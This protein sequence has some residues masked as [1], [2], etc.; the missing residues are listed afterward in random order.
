M[1]GKSTMRLLESIAYSL[2]LKVFT[3]CNVKYWKCIPARTTLIK[4]SHSALLNCTLGNDWMGRDTFAQ[5]V[6]GNVK[7]EQ[8]IREIC[9]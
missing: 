6:K 3:K 8:R 9:K 2:N 4:L 1:A 5:F 7:N